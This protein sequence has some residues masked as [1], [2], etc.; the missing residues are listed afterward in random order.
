MTTITQLVESALKDNPNDDAYERIID[1]VNKTVIDAVLKKT[2]GN[3]SI[4]ARELGINRGTFRQKMLKAGYRTQR[5]Q[6]S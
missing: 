6:A 5:M 1:E 3:Q 2:Y 4:A